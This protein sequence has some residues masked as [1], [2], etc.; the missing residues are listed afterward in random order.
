[1]HTILGANGV[2]GREL[3]CSLRGSGLA[4]RQVGR[5]PQS[6]GPGD[7]MVSADLLDPK[8]TDAAVAGSDVVHLLVGL[9]YDLEVWREQWPRVMRNVIDARQ[10]HRSRL[11]FFDNVYAYGLVEGA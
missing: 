11:A 4:L 3:S 10:R 5:T 9:K 8:A 2:I 1:M 7:E 6:E